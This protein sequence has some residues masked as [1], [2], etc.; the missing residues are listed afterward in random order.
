MKAPQPLVDAIAILT[1]TVTLLAAVEIFLRVTV[2]E[3]AP[4]STRPSDPEQIAYEFDEHY[5]VSVKANMKRTFVR[6]A[7]NG[8]DVIEWRTDGD[9]FRGAPLKQRP[10]TRIVVYGDS[11]IEARSTRTENT[12]SSKLGEH[13]KAAGV[14]DVEVVNAGVIGFGPDQSLIRL[15]LETETLEPNLVVFHAFADN[16]FGDIVRNRL[17]DLGPDDV[18]IATT[19]RK[20]IDTHLLAAGARR[21]EGPLSSLFVVQATRRLSRLIRAENVP[22]HTKADEQVTT[23]Q[24]LAADEYA[25]Y[26]RSAPRVASHFADH[27]DIDVALATD[28]ESSKVKVKLMGAVLRH[29]RDEAA[30]RGIQFVVLIQPSRVDLTELGPLNY[31]YLAKYPTYRSSRLTDVVE[32]ICRDNG[33]PFVNL[34]PVFKVNRPAELFFKGNDDHWNDRGQDLAARETASYIVARRLLAGIAPDVSVAQRDPH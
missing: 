34:F 23:L 31:K 12:Y 6:N 8:G 19:H 16:D 25:V 13:L 27:Y 15:S 32:Q 2:P 18:L 21:R 22:D 3:E 17:F 30:S 14:T 29:A 26:K 1:V 28:E 5:L 10:A 4:E 20:T 9:G 11:N 24:K 33:I 7:E